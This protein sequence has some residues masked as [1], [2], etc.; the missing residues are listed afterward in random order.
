[1]PAL[2]KRAKRDA[3]LAMNSAWIAALGDGR[4]E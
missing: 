4:V 3:D 1:M 2:N